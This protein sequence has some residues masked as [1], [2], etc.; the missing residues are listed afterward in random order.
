MQALTIDAVQKII[1]AELKSFSE[2]LRSAGKQKADDWMTLPELIRILP[3][4]PSRHTVYSWCQRGKIPY[5]KA[6][7]KLIFKRSEIDEFLKSYGKPT[8][9]EIDAEVDKQVR[10]LLT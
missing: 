10:H 3:D 4:K 9:A 1:R 8:R 2:E 5:H 7:K 6:N